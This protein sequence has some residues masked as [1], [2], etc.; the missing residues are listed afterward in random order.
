ML[1][2]AQNGSLKIVRKLIAKGADPD[3]QDAVGVAPLHI[4]SDQV[5]FV[6]AKA[7]H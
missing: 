3:K 7:V 6:I 5:W 1:L 4:A 2:A